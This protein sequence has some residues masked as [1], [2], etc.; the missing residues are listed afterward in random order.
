MLEK[1]LAEKHEKVKF[2]EGEHH[3]LRQKL[4][5]ADMQLVSDLE[6]IRKLG[7]D[8]EQKQKELEE[9]TTAAQA[10]CEVVDPTVDG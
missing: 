7:Q 6:K 4:K 5:D 10:L 2:L 3:T 9:M 1:S 8:K